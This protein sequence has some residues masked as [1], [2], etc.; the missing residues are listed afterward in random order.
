MAS[1]AIM[2]STEAKS[3]W[4][5]HRD[6]P[7]FGKLPPELRILVWSFANEGSREVEIDTMGFPT[8]VYCKECSPPNLENS[9]CKDCRIEP[10][11][12]TASIPTTLHACKESRMEARKKYTLYMEDNPAEIRKS[13]VYFNPLTDK[14]VIKR[15]PNWIRN[16]HSPSFPVLG[17]N[18]QKIL[19]NQLLYIQ[20]FALD[21]QRLELHNVG[22]S[23]CLL[24]EK[25]GLRQFANLKEVWYYVSKD[26]AWFFTLR[27]S[28]AAV[29]VESTKKQFAE[30]WKGVFETTTAPTLTVILS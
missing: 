27:E 29:Y 20:P 4:A 28:S 8:M 10:L 3:I 19:D 2:S 24:D 30:R 17:P 18:I 7:K 13:P 15:P 16:I 23:F 5:G 14:V 22:W 21:V 12:I 25:H 9:Q 26:T 1:K 6:F 11:G